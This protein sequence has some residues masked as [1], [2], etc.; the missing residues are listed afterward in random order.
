[1]R[2]LQLARFIH[3]QGWTLAETCRQLGISPD[4]LRRYL[5]S[6]VA[7]PRSIELACLALERY[8]PSQLE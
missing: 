3:E 8:P 7:I 5:R 1:M 4:R 2:T 6:E